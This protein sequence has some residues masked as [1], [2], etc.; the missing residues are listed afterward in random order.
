MRLTVANSKH[1]M[2]RVYDSRGVQIRTAIAFDTKTGQMELYL[3][4]K[5]K[6]KDKLICTQTTAYDKPVIVKV[7]IKGAYATIDGKK[8]TN[9]E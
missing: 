2:V 1:R 4:G 8:I 3:T 5:F 7:K 6:G 9:K